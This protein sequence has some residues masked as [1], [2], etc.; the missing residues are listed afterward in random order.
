ML[1]DQPVFGDWESDLVSVN[2]SYLTQLR[3]AL[4][5][6]FETAINAFSI[7]SRRMAH[8]LEAI[9]N[10][11][12]ERLAA[13][14]SGNFLKFDEQAALDVLVE[15]SVSGPLDCEVRL[16]V[17]D[18]APTSHAWLSKTA[19][20]EPD[21][22]WANDLRDLRVLYLLCMRDGLREDIGQAVIVF[23]LEVKR[24]AY[25]LARMTSG[26][27]QHLAAALGSDFMSFRQSLPLEILIDRLGD[28]CGEE[29]LRIGI[30]GHAAAHMRN[31]ASFFEEM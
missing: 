2:R 10:V 31:G 25:G 29:E 13:S 26:G 5:A 3:G 4:R 8:Q 20:Y 19:E 9:D 11:A 16:K 30:M 12:L 24:F 7:R 21:S 18:S 15:S 6:D 27:I 17:R 28:G 22:P 1:Q 23:G 14:L